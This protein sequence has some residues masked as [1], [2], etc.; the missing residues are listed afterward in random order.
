MNFQNETYPQNQELTQKTSFPKY[1]LPGKRSWSWLPNRKKGN[2]AS[3]WTY[4]KWNHDFFGIVRSC[5]S[6]SLL[7]NIPNIYNKP[8]WFTLSLILAIWNTTAKDISRHFFWKM[9]C[10]FL[11]G[12]TRI[13]PVKLSDVPSILSTMA[14]HCR[15]YSG[16]LLK[17]KQKPIT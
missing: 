1:S 2:F 11:L 13:S 17:K 8:H 3:F 4:H 14:A 9:H 16:Y 15:D 10:T 12:R 5:S 7:N 6:F